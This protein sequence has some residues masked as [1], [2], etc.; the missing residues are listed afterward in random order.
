MIYG[1]RKA[2]GNG[3]NVLLSVTQA[4][5][6]PKIILRNQKPDIYSRF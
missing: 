5:R 2:Y 4:G 6:V 3:V 1:D